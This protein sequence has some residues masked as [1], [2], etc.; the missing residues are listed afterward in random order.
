MKIKSTWIAVAAVAS[1]LCLSQFYSVSK[2]NR[3]E[4]EIPAV[5]EVKPVLSAS[6]KPTLAPKKEAAPVADALVPVAASEK[7]EPT[8]QEST[9]PENTS[10]LLPSS[11]T[12]SREYNQNELV[13][14]EPLGT[15]RCHL[16]IDFT[17]MDSEN[18]IA[19][20]DGKV[21]RVYEDYLY[22]K[23]VTIDHGNGLLSIYAS[24]REAV[25]SE[26]AQITKG[27][28]LGYMGESAPAEPGVHLHFAM[29]KDGKY[30]DPLGDKS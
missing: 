30:I 1:A 6:P 22:G 3:V 26:G 20:S 11:G 17:P 19:V 28:L 2:Q 29:Q 9:A 4:T 18:V 24:L 25:V 12:V 16:A 7:P 23:T 27:T 13:Y 8:P 15:W 5:S 14:F 21:T 10:F